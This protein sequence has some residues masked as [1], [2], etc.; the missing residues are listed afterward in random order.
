M[1][2]D[3]R[4]VPHG[5]TLQADV[6]V[7]GAGPAGIT[8]AE[9]LARAGRHVLLVEAA[10]RE[11]T[12]ADD[13]ALDGDGSGEPFP[14]VRSR[15]RGFGGTSTHWTPE[16]GLRV[17]PLDELDFDARP[18][19]PH[20]AWPVNASELRPYYERAYRS[21]GLEPENEARRWFGDD[22]PTPLSWPG[23][24][25]LAMFQFAPH[26]S[27]TRRFDSL[28]SASLIDL[29][30]H[31]TVTS[32]EQGAQD[33]AV[34]RV[35]IANADG[36]HCY[37]V[38]GVVVL[39]C[40]ALENARL[41]LASPGRDG[42]AL[43]NDHDNVGRYFM[44][45]LSVDSGIL[46]PV[47]GHDLGAT[48]FREQRS[49]GGDRFQPMLWLA[50]ELIRREG[51]PNAAFWVEEIDPMYLSPGVGT[52]RKARAAIHGRPR[53]ALTPQLPGLVRDSPD[54]IRYFARRKLSVSGPT[55]VAL[56]ILTEQVPN[57]ESRV[58]LSARRDAVGL[59]RVDLDWRIT[60][61]DLDVVT[62]HQE[63]LGKQLSDRGVATLGA[64]FRRE[65]H[66][67]PIMSNFHHLGTTRMHR[68]SRRGVVDIDGRVH[69]TSNVYVVGGSV[70]P[71]GGYLNPTL[72]ILALAL[73]AAEKINRRWTPATVHTARE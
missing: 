54:L 43:G 73:R 64:P 11:H 28:S 10:G 59:P 15:H 2:I 12:R 71:T 72:T 34:E 24:P 7:I 36:G 41:L 40:G 63:L 53:R 18:C 49:T 44:D 14:L 66:P 22:S 70:F 61:A 30:M 16:T 57:R 32:L 39:A 45:H 13:D 35:V 17:R 8:M 38:G 69:A 5:M 46:V 51:I 56:R 65:T 67:S 62:A 33:T 42:C 9:E 20:D 52:A 37:A 68:D 23:G 26:D 27:F 58:R 21:I 48:V 47:D 25:Q 19:R 1:L 29:A 3:C 4:L 55:V 60:S 31:G 50:N 6:V